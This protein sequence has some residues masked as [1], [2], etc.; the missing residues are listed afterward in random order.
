[1]SKISS[2]G[3]WRSASMT[4]TRSPLDSASPALTALWCPKFR[5]KRSKVAGSPPAIASD[6]SAA[7][8][9]LLPSS[10]ST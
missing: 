1:M 7:D 9:S 3:S 2:G 5:E 8:R 6:A 4:A 10:T